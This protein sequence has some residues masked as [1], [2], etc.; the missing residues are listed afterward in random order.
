MSFRS[1]YIGDRAFYRMLFAVLIPIVV[2]NAITNLVSLLDNMMVGQVGTEAMSGVSIAN[3]LFFIFNI[4]LFGAI[5]GA[6]I[7]GA[8]FA[9][10][11]DQEGLRQTLRYKFLVGLLLLTAALGIFLSLHDQLISLYLTEDGTGDLELTLRSGR[12]YLKVMLWGLPPFLITQCYASTLRETGETLLPMKGGILAVGINVLLNYLLIFGKLGLPALGVTGAALATVISR[13]GEMAFVLVGT[14]R[15]KGAYPFVQG[16]YTSF[17]LPWTLVRRITIK[18]APL[19]LNEFLWSLGMS[20][21]LQCYSTRGLNV[22]A[23][24]NIS[25]TV[26][27]LFLVV[28][29]ALGSA[30]SIL[31]GQML[32]AG[33]KQRARDSAAKLIAFSVFLCVGVGAVMAVVSPFI[34]RIYNTTEEVRMLATRFLWICSAVMPITGFLN[35]CYFTLRAGGNTI[36][37]FLFDSVFLWCVGIPAAYLTSRYTAMPVLEIFLVVQAADLLKCFVGYAM[38]KKGIWIRNI[39]SS[40]TQGELE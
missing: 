9:G 7:F 36:I 10:K 35:S 15:K 28:A 30:I 22:V 19:L 2:Q 40:E 20:V 13:F 16:L 5:S 25:S 23:A 31:I 29:L 12:E 18:G 17:R 38:V 21:L 6:G 1:K 27:N 11:G 24:L 37:T 8:Q 14:H 3:Q 4:T 26:N 33:E 34:P 39:V 32:G